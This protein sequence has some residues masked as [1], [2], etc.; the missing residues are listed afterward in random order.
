MIKLRLVFSDRTV[1]FNGDL[2]ECLLQIMNARLHKGFS[3]YEFSG[4]R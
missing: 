2:M 3:H 4:A 1:A